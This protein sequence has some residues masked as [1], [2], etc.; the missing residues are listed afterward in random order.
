MFT[1]FAMNV[2]DPSLT[3][4]MSL[5][6]ENISVFAPTSAVNVVNLLMVFVPSVTFPV[7]ERLT[8]ALE[9]FLDLGR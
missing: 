7:V 2:P 5:S 3:A 1:L 6:V 9:E 8:T 4:V